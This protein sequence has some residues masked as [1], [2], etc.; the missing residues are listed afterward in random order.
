MKSWSEFKAVCALV[1]ECHEKQSAHI[2]TQEF[3]HSNE[4]VW[5]RWIAEWGEEMA[6]M[7][8]REVFHGA[9]EL[10]LFEITEE[11]DYG[12]AIER[13]YFLREVNDG[14]K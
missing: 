13:T 2:W 5:I 1:A 8:K 12:Q 6:H 14:K 7:V 3:K 4:I 9:L 10:G 11:N